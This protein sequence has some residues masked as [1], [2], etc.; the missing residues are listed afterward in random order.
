MVNKAN[1]IYLYRNFTSSSLKT[2]IPELVT[3]Y[4]D[5]RLV[6]ETDGAKQIEKIRQHV[7][8]QNFL[9]LDREPTDEE[10][11]NNPKIA[12]F[13]GYAGENAYRLDVNEQ[14]ARQLRTVIETEFGESPVSIRTMGGS[15][16]IKT[17][18]DEL[19]IPTIIVPM[20]N[21]D[22]N[23]HNPNENIRIGNISDGILLCMAILKMKLD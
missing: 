2:I 1:L 19:G 13:I 11:L 9:V 23:Q 21:M 7:I 4:M 3:V 8:A 22:N 17:F 16:P 15:V 20:V 18:I 12:K 5:V 10:R 6:A 14:I